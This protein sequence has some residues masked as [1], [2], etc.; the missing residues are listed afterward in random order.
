MYRIHKLQKLY[1]DSVCDIEDN[2][3]IYGEELKEAKNKGRTREGYPATTKW[4]E[5]QSKA[6][7]REELEDR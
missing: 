2:I 4:Q 1:E 7:C 3:V 5:H 6:R